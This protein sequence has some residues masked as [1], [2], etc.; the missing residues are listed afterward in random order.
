MQYDNNNKGV[1]FN[2][3]KQGNEKR[4][5]YTGSINVDGKEFKLSAWIKDGKSGNKFMSL[6]VQPKENNGYEVVIEDPVAK[7]VDLEDTYIPF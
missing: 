3:D 1:L 5:D 7:A 4:P 6:S 2:N